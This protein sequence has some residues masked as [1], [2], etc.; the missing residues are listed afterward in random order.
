MQFSDKYIAVCGASALR[1]PGYRIH[2]ARTCSAFRNSSAQS[3]ARRLGIRFDT[4]FATNINLYISCN[5]SLQSLHNRNIKQ[6][7]SD[8]NVLREFTDRIRYSKENLV[9]Q[10]CLDRVDYLPEQAKWRWRTRRSSLMLSSLMLT[11]GIAC[12]MTGCASL[13]A[14]SERDPRDHAERF[15]RAI[16]KFNTGL[17][18]TILRPVARGYEKVTSPSVRT[19]VSNFFANLGYPKT[20]F[21]DLFQGHVGDFAS[22]IA[23]FS[24]NTT[25][26]VVG[27]FDPASRFGLERH[28][29]D[30]G[31][32]LGK[33]GLPTGT[34]LMLPLLGPSDVRDGAGAIPDHFLSI[35]GQIPDPVL[36]AGLT[37]ADRVNGRANMLSLDK[38][39]DSA[40]DPY[41][42]VR[43]VWF[44]RRDYKVHGDAEPG[45]KAPDIDQESLDPDDR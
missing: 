41:A 32:T 25:I 31:Q 23:R 2:H 13:P 18:H 45:N 40:Y 3:D 37:V 20:I 17:D 33:W 38:A 43:N 42:F 29:R 27:V 1:A 4:S 34:Y 26:G 19:H 7:Q 11:V 44:Q 28:D 21:N 6:E 12:L 39:I 5:A 22:D 15:N 35:E 10:K 14:G 9:L 30:F 36:Q 8:A 24:V 16:Y